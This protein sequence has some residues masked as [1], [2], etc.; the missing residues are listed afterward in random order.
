LQT[1]DLPEHSIFNL[2][3][4]QGK[5]ICRKAIS[6]HSEN[7]IIVTAMIPSGVYAYTIESESKMIIRGKWRK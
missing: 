6:A 1:N 2:V 7:I 4:I 3:D 5:I